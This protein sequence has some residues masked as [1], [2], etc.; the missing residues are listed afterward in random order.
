MTT[1]PQP[2]HV[3]KIGTPA[4]SREIASDSI[5]SD[6]RWFCVYTDPNAEPTVAAG[7]IETGFVAYL[8]RIVKRQKRYGRIE[9]ILRP[10]FPRYVLAALDLA[11]DPWGLVLRVRGVKRFLTAPSG[12]PVAL[13]DGEVERLQRL[14]RA[15]DGAIDEDEPA[16]HP[17]EQARALAGPLEGFAGICQ[18]SDAQRVGMLMSMF[19]RN[20]AVTFNAA[21]LERVG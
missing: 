14:G 9:T 6:H 13:R 7:I 12:L 5:S 4:R 3:A 16:I 19:G 10:A 21:D 2:A 11:C 20:C 8:P 15:S 18:W 1:A 17:G